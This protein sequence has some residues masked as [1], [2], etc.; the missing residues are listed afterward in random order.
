MAAEKSSNTIHPNTE[1]EVLCLNGDHR[2]LLKEIT[3]GQFL[4]MKRKEGWKY[5]L[6]QVGQCVTI[7]TKTMIYEPQKQ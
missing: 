4:A 7:P 2:V 1:V 6:F 5:I 3:H